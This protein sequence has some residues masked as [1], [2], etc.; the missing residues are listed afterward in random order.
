[1]KSKGQVTVFIIVGLAVLLIFGMIFYF[2]GKGTEVEVPASAQPLKLYV[3]SCLKS[4][5]HQGIQLLGIQGGYIENISN[6]LETEYS[7]LPYYYDKGELK[8][9]SKESLENELA[10]F[11]DNSLSNCINNF[12][13]FEGQN[14]S[15]EEVLSKVIILDNKVLV[16]LDYPVTLF[17]DNNR[18]TID[19]FS[20]EV[21]SSLGYVNN[22]AIN[23]INNIAE[24][25]SE[26]RRVGK[27]CRSRWSPYH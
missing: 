14:I 4:I 26:E 22:V 7:N 17:N 18:I 1:M 10:F 21:D 24:D 13:V 3:E 12:N 5:T 23:V 25:R 11:I 15:S 20:I 16:E 9:I 6:S 27:E 2:V 8:V 19:K